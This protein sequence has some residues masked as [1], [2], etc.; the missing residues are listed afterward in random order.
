MNTHLQK[1]FSLI[2]ILALMLMVVP[3]QSAQAAG[4]GSGAIGLTSLGMAYTQ[5]FNTLANTG[6]TNNLTINGWFLDE[7]GSSTR[8]NGQY[9]AGTGSD[10]AGDAYSFGASGSAERAYGTLRS[11][12]LNPTM[13][14]QFTNNTGSTVTALDVSYV[15]EMW[16]AGVTN[17]NAADRINFQLSTD[18]TS[19]TTGTLVDYDSLDFNSPNINTA[20]GAVNGNSV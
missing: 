12:T 3:M 7:T 1:V 18:A 13:G 4:G 10:N 2:T 8:N 9:A 15:G 6:T 11:G 17:R 16:R 20:A 14:A 5:D 19:L